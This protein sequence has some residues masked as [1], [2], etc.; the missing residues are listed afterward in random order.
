MQCPQYSTVVPSFLSTPIFKKHA[1]SI[2][3]FY[4]YAA[5]LQSVICLSHDGRVRRVL[6]PMFWSIF[7]TTWRNCT[8]T[9]LWSPAS[10]QHPSSKKMQNQCQMSNSLY[11]PKSKVISSMMERLEWHPMTHFGL[12]LPFCDQIPTLIHCGLQQPVNP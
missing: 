10:Y 5:Q 8:K 1:K 7:I 12:K 9:I 6:Y 4:C 3:N 2:S 11:P